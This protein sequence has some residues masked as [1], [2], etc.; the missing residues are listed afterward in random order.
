MA[1]IKDKVLFYVNSGNQLSSTSNSF[2]YILDMKDY[3]GYDRI[4]I[5]QAQIPISYWIVEQGLNTFQLRE[6]N[7]TVTITIQ[8]GNYNALS[9]ATVIPA[10]LNASSPNGLIYTISVPN[11][12][13]QNNNGLLSYRVNSSAVTCSF[14]FS[15]NNSINELFGFNIGSTA[16]FTVGSGSSNLTSTNVVKFVPEDTIF[17]HSSLVDNE[18]DDV[19][20]EIYFGNNTILSNQSFINPCPLETSKKFMSQKSATFSITNENGRAIYFNGLNV[21]FTI[22]I[23]KSYSK[24]IDTVLDFMKSVKEY[25]DK[26]IY[27]EEHSEYETV[28]MIQNQ[29]QIENVQPNE[30]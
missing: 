9:F 24:V 18:H 7:T 4:C 6:N 3:V 10:L 12:A 14:I 8:P 19:L 13:S 29:Q 23:W 17:I 2:T 20:Q 15:S 26:R 11:N 21:T 25:M 28:P 22:M 30:T 5:T 16:T 1:F 27:M